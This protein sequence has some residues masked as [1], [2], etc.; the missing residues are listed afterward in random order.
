VI[1][2]FHTHAFPDS[3]AQRAMS[4]LQ[5]ETNEVVA[6]LDGRLSSLLASMD[7][8]GIRRAVVCSIATKP[9][10]FDP[11]LRWSRTIASERIVPFLSVHPDDP[12][13]PDRLDAAAREGFRGIKMHPYYQDF[14]LDEERLFPLYEQMSELGLILACHTG[15][16]IAFPRVRKAD[17]RRIAAV[18][19]RVPGLT[20]V[21]T[22]MGSWQDWTEVERHLLGKPI[23]M[24]TSFSLEY[25]PRDCLKRILAAHPAT[26]LLFGTDSP[27]QDQSAAL[28]TVRSLG[29][30]PELERAILSENAQRLLPAAD[31]AANSPGGAPLA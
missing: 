28:R 3:L 1:T 31:R 9:E 17:P 30:A 14:D 27:W 25:M 19:A 6:V 16:D 29:L 10:Q 26:H 4:R 11:I 21:T 15:F 18:A 8:A 2:D 22:H 12:A 24:E 20:L 23:Y 7:R 13:A 5:A